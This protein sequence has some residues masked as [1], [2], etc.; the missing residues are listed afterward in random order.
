MRILHVTPTYF[1]ATRY[2]GPIHSVHG[3]A[4][5]QAKRG[6]ETHVFTTNVDGAGVSDVPVGQPVEMDG[7]RVTYFPC[8]AGRR[9]YR[10]PPMA[11]A[12]AR[13]VGE[14]DMLHLHAAF[15]WPP[16][17]AARIAQRRGKPYVYAPRGMLAPELI[18]A[19]SRLVKTLWI[20]L[21]ERRSVRAASALHVT[22][23]AEAEG[24]RALGFRPRRIALIP[25]GV[26]APQADAGVQ[27][28]TPQRILCI[29]RISWKKRLDLL[30]R[31]FATT[32][33]A[34][35]VIAGND[36]EGLT[37]S[38]QNLAEELGVAA[39][40]H[41]HGPVQ[42]EEKWRL[43][44]S[45]TLF[46]LASQ[47]E[48]FGNVALEAMACGAPVVVTPG[49]GLAPTIRD[50]GA[51]LVVE[52][53]ALSFGRALDELLRDPQRRAAMGDAGRRAAQARFSW[54]AIADQTDQLYRELLSS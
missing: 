50:I 39:R 42:G 47:S 52:G 27:V 13:F 22:S 7:V 31:A 15:L 14:V 46:A 29:G 21:F 48:N 53:D 4:R 38:L 5:A 30:I 9:L 6:D 1:P 8:G 23:A 33:G 2:G 36:D 37:P 51:G 45:A 40:V 54:G 49:V 17:A 28:A 11:Q 32:S 16:L 18:R 10:A 25:N 34:E 26:D 43:L 24:V 3:L 12:L 44:R 41:F 19:K 20:E 35:L